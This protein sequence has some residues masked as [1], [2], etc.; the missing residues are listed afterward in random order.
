MSGICGFGKLTVR[1][2]TEDDQNV[3]DGIYELGQLLW[4]CKKC[5]EVW[6]IHADSMNDAE[7]K[8]FLKKEDGE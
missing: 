7:V 8:E 3:Q 2:A 6:R 4:D 1:R 5:G